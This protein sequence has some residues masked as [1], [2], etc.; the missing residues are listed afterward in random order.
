[1]WLQCLRRLFLR[2]SNIKSI[3]E[4][5]KLLLAFSRMLLKMTL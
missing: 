1:M 5:A 2:Q 4:E 3:R